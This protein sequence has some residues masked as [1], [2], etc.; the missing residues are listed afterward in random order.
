MNKNLL[1]L[2]LVVFGTACSSTTA[3]KFP[4]I[5]K[6]IPNQDNEI[7]MK[8]EIPDPEWTTLGSGAYQDDSGKAV[9]YG[10]GSVSKEEDIQDSKTLSEDRARNELA[11]VL[12]S[13]ME[14]LVGDI[15]KSK[16]NNAVKNINKSELN[17]SL[18]EGSATI[19]MEANIAKQWLNPESGKV[20]SMAKLDLSRLT[21]KLDN[22]G[23]VSAED[24]SF[25]R[26]TIIKAHTNMTNDIPSKDAFRVQNEKKSIKKGRVLSY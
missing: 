23:K 6:M 9:F 13:Y 21:E 17:N 1:F 2:V 25:L 12:T 19:L 16:P 3:G 4:D 5:S 14:H 8:Q 7:P 24:K 15:K 10:V 18:E 11:K 22:F 20:Y 26:R